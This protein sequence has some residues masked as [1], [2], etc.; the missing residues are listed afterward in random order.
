[1]DTE[2]ITEE[3]KNRFHDKITLQEDKFILKFLVEKDELLNVMGVLKETYGFNHLANVTSVD[4]GEEFELVYHLYS[5]P[6]N[7]KI[8]IKTRTPR[9]SAQV[10]SLF[11]IWPTAD[12]QER[13][14]YDLMG[15]TFKGH[16]NLVR[17]LLPDDFT[18]H[19]LRK[20]FA[21]KG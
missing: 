6:E 2:K 1:M 18:G 4:Y 3:L 11:G 8:C 19:P 5:I 14:V 12:W 20:D 7:H 13:E 9:N 10:D 17:V 21:K 16:P 15:I